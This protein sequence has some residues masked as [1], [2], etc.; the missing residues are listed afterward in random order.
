MLL[1]LLLSSSEIT[2]GVAHH[3]EFE[4]EADLID[5]YF[6]PRLAAGSNTMRCHSTTVSHHSVDQPVGETNSELP[7]AHNPRHIITSRRPLTC[8]GSDVCCWCSAAK[9]RIGIYFQPIPCYTRLLSRRRSRLLS[10]VCPF[11]RNHPDAMYRK[12]EKRER[13]SNIDNI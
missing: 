5:W 2:A 6:Y 11:M 10:P 3:A 12:C 7:I 9:T 8:I 1:I 4:H 13:S